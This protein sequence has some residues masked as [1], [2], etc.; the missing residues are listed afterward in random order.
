MLYNII[1]EHSYVALPQWQQWNLPTSLLIIKES[2]H[3]IT[4]L[5]H[6]NIHFPHKQ[7]N[8]GTTYTYKK[9]SKTSI[10]S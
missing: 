2:T 6:I 5:I 3:S 10:K 7:S 9:P 8:Y 1:N 4:E